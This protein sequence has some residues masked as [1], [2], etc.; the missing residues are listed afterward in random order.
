MVQMIKRMSAGRA[1]SLDEVCGFGDV[2]F[3]MMV[4][5][6]IGFEWYPETQLMPCNGWRM[7]GSPAMQRCEGLDMAEVDEADRDGCFARICLRKG[8]TNPGLC[9]SSRDG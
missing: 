8:R 9:A 4:A 7:A 1:K 6:M 5:D 3:V 2:K